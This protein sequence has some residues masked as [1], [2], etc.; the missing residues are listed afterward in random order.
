MIFKTLWITLRKFRRKLFKTKSFSVNDTVAV[1]V[2]S[3]SGY[4]CT[5]MPARVICV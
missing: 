5:D 4:S 2:C 1:S 3:M